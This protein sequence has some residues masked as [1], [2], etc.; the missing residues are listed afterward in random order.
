ML[1]FIQ[2]RVR[3]TSTQHAVT[4]V[5]V[6]GGTGAGVAS[7]IG[8]IR[9]RVAPLSGGGYFRTRDVTRISKYMGT[10]GTSHARCTPRICRGKKHE[11]IGL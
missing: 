5:L 11:S 9:D 10:T 4:V 3:R 1:S 8:D 7:P 2:Q 6:A